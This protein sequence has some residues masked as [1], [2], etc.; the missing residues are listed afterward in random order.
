VLTERVRRVH[1]SATLTRNC[2][3][4][5]VSVISLVT[6]S[7]FAQTCKVLCSKGGGGGSKGR[8]SVA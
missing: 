5:I 6:S 4:D 8:N 1:C 3:V 7:A 2:G